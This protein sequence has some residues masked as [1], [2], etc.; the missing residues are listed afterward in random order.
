[1]RR[2]RERTFPPYPG[3]VTL[4]RV[5]ALSLWRSWDPELGWGRIAEAG[6]E[7]KRIPGAHFDIL[8]QPHVS[9]LAAELKASLERTWLPA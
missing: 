5:Q 8:E 9:G 7:V 2:Y 1:M 4:F 3:R 6:V